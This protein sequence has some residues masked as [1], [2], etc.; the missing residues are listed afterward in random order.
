M[1]GGE[2]GIER[3]TGK[4][5]EYTTAAKTNVLEGSWEGAACQLTVSN[6]VTAAWSAHSQTARQNRLLFKLV[7]W[8]VTLWLVV[9]STVQPAC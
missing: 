6:Q 8:D 2:R 4:Q 3:L 1:R 7:P 5:L 9:P